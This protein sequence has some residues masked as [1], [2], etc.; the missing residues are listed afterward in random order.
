MSK[1]VAARVIGACAAIGLSLGGVALRGADKS[2]AV[3][4]AAIPH[5]VSPAFAAALGIEFVKDSSSSVIVERGGKRYVVDLVARTVREADPAPMPAHPISGNTEAGSAFMAPQVDGARVFKDHCA[6]CH[7]PEGKGVPDFKTPNFTDPKI[8]ASLTDEQILSTIENGKKGT[9]MPAWRTELPAAEIKAAA[10]HIRSFGA[11]GNQQQ[12][13]AA[14]AGQEQNPKVYKPGDDLLLSLPTGRRLTRHGFYINFT[15][16][17]AFDPAFSGT[18]RG[19]A[20]AGLDGFSLSSFGFRYGVTDKFSVSIYRSPT[21]IGR[22]I[23]MMAAY[24]FLD[25]RDGQP[26]NAAVRFSVEGQNNFARNFTENIEGVF[27]RSITRRAQIYFVPTVS[28]NDHKLFS[29]N[30][31]LSSQIPILPG[32][33]AV[34]LGAGLSVDVRPTVALVAEVIPT[35]VNGRPLGIHRPAY[36][37]GI[38]KKIWRHAFTFGFTTSPGTTVSQ[39]AGTVASFLGDPAADKPRGMFIG[40]DLTRQIF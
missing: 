7:G 32:Y 38:Q 35:V 3:E 18:A 2:E 31:Y 26:L 17:F 8:Q 23:Q 1:R 5:E 19:G 22:P 33:D 40:F 21:F 15:H 4:A 37:F 29:P 20:L 25:E 6:M 30:G 27:S 16:R 39:R 12:R 14:Q 9:P 28:F 24:N 13:A 10:A 36:S 11:G 34:S